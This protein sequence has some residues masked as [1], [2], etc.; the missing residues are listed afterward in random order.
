M[1]ALLL[2]W[3]MIATAALGLATVLSTGLALGAWWA[4]KK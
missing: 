1:G 3:P 4:E 2:E